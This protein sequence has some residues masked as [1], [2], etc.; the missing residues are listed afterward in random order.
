ML[1]ANMKNKKCGAG[2]GKREFSGRDDWDIKLASNDVQ[3]NFL[4]KSDIIIRKLELQE[5][6]NC[7]VFLPHK[8]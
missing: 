6:E 4:P 5:N 7:S 8:V 3:G 1:V 2:N